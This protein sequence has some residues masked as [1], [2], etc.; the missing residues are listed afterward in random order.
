MLTKSPGIYCHSDI[1][2]KTYHS[3]FPSRKFSML[4]KYT[5]IQIVN[6]SRLKPISLFNI[7]SKLQVFIYQTKE[8]LLAMKIV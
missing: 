3:F 2:D 8:L 1:N 6:Y 7:I 5:N 4:K